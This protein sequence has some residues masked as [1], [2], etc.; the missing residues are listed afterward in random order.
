MK[1]PSI[2]VWLPQEDVFF[3]K[4]DKKMT[5]KQFSSGEVNLG[6]SKT[7]HWIF[8][9]Q[10]FLCWNEI[11]EN[12]V[13]FWHA[14]GKIWTKKNWILAKRAK[15][16]TKRWI[17]T[18]KGHNFDGE[19]S[20]F[21]RK[22][23]KIERKKVIIGQKNVKNGRKKVNIGKIKSCFVEK[24]Q[25]FVKKMQN[26]GKEDTNLVKKIQLIT[27]SNRWSHLISKIKRIS[28]EIRRFVALYHKGFM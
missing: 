19:H 4:N 6:R 25:N 27:N 1:F 11:L 12:Q 16:L 15:T 23:V 18:E 20:E 10:F 5:K 8:F 28:T 26:F 17:L 2:Y 21:G 24:E 22:K 7:F 9:T 13:E 3:E 14:E